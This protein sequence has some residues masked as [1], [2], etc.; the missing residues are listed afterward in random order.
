MEKLQGNY[1]V[2]V[3][4]SLRKRLL[5]KLRI[6]NGHRIYIMSIVGFFFFFL[7]MV[8]D[9]MRY[10]EGKI[11]AGNVYWYLFINHIFFL[12]FIFPILTIHIKREAFA[13]GRF[14]YGKLFIYT[15]TLFLGVILITMA[16]LSLIDRG[17][18]TMYSIYIIIA[19]FGLLMLHQ[20]RV[21]LNTVSFLIILVAI[22]LLYLQQHELLFIYI[23]EAV[24][25]TVTSFAVSTQMFNAYVREV[26]LDKLLEDKNEKI[27][28]EKERGDELLHNILPLDIAEELK[29]NGYVKPRHFSS[30][31]IM[32]I[33]FK[34]FSLI[35]RSLTTDQ[36]IAD[37]DHCFKQFDQITT[38]YQLEKIKTI[39]D[40]YLC[41]GGIPESNASH[42]FD[43]IEAARE[44]LSFLYDWK[45]EKTTLNEPYFE[46]RIGIHTGPVIAGV[47][48]DKKFA[49][50]VWGDA[51]NIAARIE[52]NGEAGKINISNTTYELIKHKYTCTHRG[53]ITIKN[54]KPVHMYFVEP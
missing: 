34:N 53:K 12:F 2:L 40:A 11:S 27:E 5:M 28:M 38:K 4:H 29:A 15:W 43:T 26:Y 39:G 17:A 18:L 48:G 19:N 32:L 10:A 7:F 23:L 35:S 36:L 37:L 24:G 50:D 42:P 31:T 8:L 3:P 46:G 49:F 33:D 52:A 41:A 9:Y 51:V 25:V 14:K 54:H 44:I 30:A 21:L 47:V 22:F 1:F 20:D 16:I 13:I 6:E 45:I